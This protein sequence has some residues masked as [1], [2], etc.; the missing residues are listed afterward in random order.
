MVKW[1][2]VVALVLS[3]TLAAC[4]D[5][6]G[7]STTR[8]DMG[9]AA[10]DAGA[11]DLGTAVD[12]ALPD[13]GSPGDGGPLPGDAFVPVDA[14]DCTPGECCYELVEER[15]GVFH[16]VTTADPQLIVRPLEAGEGFFCMRLEYTLQTVDNL[17]ATDEAYEGCP[18]YSH[19]AGIQGTGDEGR[20]LNAGFFRFLRLGCGVRR[21]GALEI[22]AWAPPGETRSQTLT[23]PWLPGETFRVVHEVVPFVSSIEIFQGGVHVGPRVETEITGTTVA[24]TRDT[25]IPFGLP[26]PVGG[27]FFPYYD[28]VYSDLEV[29]ASVAEA[30]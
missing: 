7:D 4:G 13:A 6:D 20:Q 8:R 30:P 14:G 11:G 3:A 18:I 26:M 15:A 23:G 27:A 17:V 1:G 2:S 10:L 29:W 22:N 28:A 9:E 24:M 25:E 5:G 16:T 12:A 19:L 21:P